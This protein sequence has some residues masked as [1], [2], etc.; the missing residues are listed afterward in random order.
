MGLIRPAAAIH[1]GAVHAAL[2]VVHKLPLKEVSR[3]VVLLTVHTADMIRAHNAHP[4]NEPLTDAKLDTADDNGAAEVSM[5]VYGGGG[6]VSVCEWVCMC[7]CVPIRMCMHLWP[8]K[9]YA[10]TNGVC[11]YV[12]VTITVMG[13]SPL[14]NMEDGLQPN[15]RCF[16]RRMAA[17][18][19]CRNT[20]S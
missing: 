8:C 19:H 10:C 4:H 7:V 1:T 3:S 13:T 17:E 11:L 6:S 5:C 18:V 15:Q 2:L 20:W 12:C 14:Q 9:F 16:R